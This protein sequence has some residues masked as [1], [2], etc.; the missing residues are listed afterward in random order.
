M[1]AGNFSSSEIHKLVKS[2]RAKDAV[3]S[4]AGLTYIQE[5]KWEQ[6]LGRQLSNETNSK[7]TSWGNLMELYVWELKMG[8]SDYLFEHKTRYSHPTILNWTGCPDLVG[9]DKVA[10]IK[11]P[12]TLKGFCEL[13]D[14]ATGEDLKESKP[15]YYWQ[16]VSNAILTDKAKAELIFFAP[17][18]SEL[19]DIRTFVDTTDVLFRNGLD[20]NKFSWMNWAGDS[21]L[22][23]LLDE[24]QYL[25]LN[26]LSFDIPESDKEFLTDRVKQAVELLKQ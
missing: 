11:C 24:C 16:L 6:K 26:V 8:I 21:D 13:A 9:E 5:K 2:G 1:R 12:F 20:Q 14:C 19:N 10:D 7:P 18:K 17:Y 4:A 25:N 3:F 22:P 23:Y 15:E